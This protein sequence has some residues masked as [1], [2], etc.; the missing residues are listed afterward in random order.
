MLWTY[1][2]VFLGK[3]NEKYKALPE[4]SM[5]EMFTLAPLALIVIVL[6]VYPSP[7]LNLLNVSL[8]SLNTAV[9][10]WSKVAGL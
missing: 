2:R 10:N 4:I 3:L 9:T 6:G 7:L 5:R 1:Q 8:T